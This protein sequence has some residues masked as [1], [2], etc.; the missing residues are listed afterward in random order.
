M[1]NTPPS[2]HLAAHIP[3]LGKPKEGQIVN[4][5]IRWLIMNGI[6]CWRNNTGAYKPEGSSS[7]VRYGFK[8]SPDIIGMTKQGRF[9]GVECKAGDNT[10]SPHQRAFQEQAEASNGLYILAYSVDDLIAKQSEIMGVL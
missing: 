1:I 6:F 2:P 7:Y 3:Q 5:C 8:G 9:L 4:A 10:Q